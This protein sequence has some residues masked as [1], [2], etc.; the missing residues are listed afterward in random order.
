[1]RSPLAEVTT[2]KRVARKKSSVSDKKFSIKMEKEN[3]TIRK[4]LNFEA[5]D[6]IGSFEKR[7][8]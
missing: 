1:M 2:G 3:S 6:V 8:E 5:T 7:I 4:E